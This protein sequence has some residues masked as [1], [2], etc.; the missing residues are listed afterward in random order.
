MYY[1]PLENCQ[2]AKYHRAIKQFPSFLDKESWTNEEKENLAKG[3]KQQFQEML[4]QRSL[5]FVR[6]LVS[7]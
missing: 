3:V 5:D 2:V 7:P 1:G 4:L 6:Y